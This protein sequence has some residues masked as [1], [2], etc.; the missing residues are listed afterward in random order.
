[1]HTKQAAFSL[2][3]L[4]VVLA[5]ITIIGSLGIPNISILSAR[6]QGDTQANLL[7]GHMNA[8]RAQ[9][10]QHAMQI[11]LCGSAN[12]RDCSGDWQ[13][14]WLTRNKSTSEVLANHTLPPP[15][16]LQWKGFNKSIIFY[17]NGTAPAANGRFHLC[18]PASPKRWE[19]VLN[20]PGRIKAESNSEQDIQGC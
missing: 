13:A 1:M 2:H 12:G 11:E 16:A 14:G 3:E 10:I 18:H 17:P 5:L 15:L 19:I 20:K 7:I 4:L 6:L 9:A 8:A